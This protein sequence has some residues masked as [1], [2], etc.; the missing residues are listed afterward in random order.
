[1][2]ASHTMKSSIFVSVTKSGWGSSTSL[3]SFSNIELKVIKITKMKI[4][5]ENHSRIE[6]YKLILILILEKS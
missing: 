1:M 2:L 6:F 3:P 5:M 4:N